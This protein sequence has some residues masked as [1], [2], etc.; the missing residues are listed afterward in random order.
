MMKMFNIQKILKIMT[1]KRGLIIIS[2]LVGLY[3]AANH[4]NAHRLIEGIKG[5]KGPKEPVEP[6]PQFSAAGKEGNNIILKSAEMEAQA[7]E[8]TSADPK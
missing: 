3:L 8:N 4:F 1:S 6:V 7:K 5:E 2:L